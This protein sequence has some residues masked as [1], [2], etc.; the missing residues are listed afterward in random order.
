MAF[1]VKNVSAVRGYGIEWFVF[2]VFVADIADNL[3][4]NIFV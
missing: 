4:Q 2:I 1:S 3:F